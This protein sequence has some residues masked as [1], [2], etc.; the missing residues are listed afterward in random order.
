MMFHAG[1]ELAAAA[2][3]T[4]ACLAAPALAEA[5]L[6]EGFEQLIADLNADD[7]ATRE[8]AYEAM[9]DERIMREIDEPILVR[10][11][12]RDDLTPEQRHRIKRVYIEWFTDYMEHAGM[13]VSFNSGG[14]NHPE[15]LIVR[16]VEGFPCH[17][18]ELLFPL[19]LVI[20][21]DGVPVRKMH[22]QVSR[23]QPPVEHLR[24]A[25]ISRA[26]G[27]SISLTI[28]RPTDELSRELKPQIEQAGAT[29]TQFIQ[30]IIEHEGTR[31]IEIDLPLGSFDDLGRTAAV[32][33][34]QLVDRAADMRLERISDD[35]TPKKQV[36]F[37]G[38]VHEENWTRYRALPHRRT[39]SDLVSADAPL[40]PMLNLDANG[41]T[42][43]RNRAL[44][45][46]VRVAI[47][48]G[49]V[50]N[51]AEMVMLGGKRFDDSPEVKKLIEA[52]DR[53][54]KEL[55]DVGEQAA[56]Q[57]RIVEDRSRPERERFLARG[58][59]EA[60]EARRASFSQNLKAVTVAID[61]RR[62]KQRAQDAP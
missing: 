45:E 24:A 12:T 30:R 27:E 2:S 37:D 25:I 39:H 8:K 47:V 58:K 7:L 44:R 4:L 50:Q 31:V 22:T 61:A 9:T 49:Q 51:Q 3:I 13:G 21:V 29:T 6:P 32:L 38:G 1:R 42:I 52:K 41:L 60:L 53:I 55:S 35:A 20:E 18:R 10:A 19:D 15:I 40:D 11:L 54:T 43:Q 23:W 59:L 36:F 5:T 48:N 46:Q 26:A 33:D 28:K 14:P 16:T 17:D 34:P 57:S 56:A 62:E